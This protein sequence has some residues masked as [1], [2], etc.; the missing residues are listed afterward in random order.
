MQSKQNDNVY[1]IALYICSVKFL[2]LYKSDLLADI[3]FGVLWKENTILLLSSVI[4]FTVLQ[5]NSCF[6]CDVMITFQTYRIL[7]T[8]RHFRQCFSYIVV[9]SFIDGG[10]RNTWRKPSTCRKSLTK[11]YLIM[12][13][14]IHPP[15]C[16]SNSQY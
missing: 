7:L 3:Y 5:I 2:R 10:N 6:M 11:F 4:N 16:D 1:C 9:V 15:E 12:L 8:F 14:R 13:Y